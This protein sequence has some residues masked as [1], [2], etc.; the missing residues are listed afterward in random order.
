[1]FRYDRSNRTSVYRYQYC[2]VNFSY[3]NVTQSA[4]FFAYKNV[5][6]SVSIFVCK[7][8]TQSALFF[9]YVK[10]NADCIVFAYIN[11]PLPLSNQKHSMEIL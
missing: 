10:C 7:N 2:T 4:L 11:A 1:M 9:A 5:T 8:L 6:Q 3:K